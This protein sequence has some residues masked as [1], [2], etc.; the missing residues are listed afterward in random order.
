MSSGVLFQSESSCSSSEEESDSGTDVSW[1][2]VDDATVRQLRSFLDSNYSK[3]EGYKAI[4]STTSD[5]SCSKETKI[6]QR[7]DSDFVALYCVCACRLAEYDRALEAACVAIELDADNAKAYALRIYIRVAYLKQP[8]LSELRSDMEA[9]DKLRNRDRGSFAITR[10]IVLDPDWHKFMKAL[11]KGFPKSYR[12][13][14]DDQ[15]A[16]FLAQHSG[17]L[18]GPWQP[19]AKRS[20]YRVSVERKCRIL[21]MTGRRAAMHQLTGLFWRNEKII[22]G[23]GE[24]WVGECP[25]DI[26]MSPSGHRLFVTGRDACVHMFDSTQ[27]EGQGRK[28]N[29]P[30]KRVFHQS[31]V[32]WTITDI[33]HHPSRAAL[34]TSSIS[35]VLNF[36]ADY[37]RDGMRSKSLILDDTR[38]GVWATR[39]TGDWQVAAGSM[40]GGIHLFDILRE[41]TFCTAHSHNSL[42]VNA[43]CT[44]H[45]DCGQRAV[46]FSGGDD[47]T[48]CLWDTRGMRRPSGVLVGHTDGI[49]SLHMSDAHSY[50]LCSNAKDQKV[51]LWDLRTGIWGTSASSRDPILFEEASGVGPRRDAFDV[52]S[53]WHPVSSSALPGRL[54]GPALG[55]FIRSLFTFVGHKVHRTLIRARLS[56]LRTTGGRYILSGSA[57]GVMQLWDIYNPSPFGKTFRATGQPLR[58]LDS[59]DDDSD[60]A[61]DW[62]DRSH[63]TRAVT[64]HPT[65]PAAMYASWDLHVRMLTAA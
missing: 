17:R 22:R 16:R 49:C 6:G 40:V 9:L 15:P 21:S 31:H 44:P 18:P 12:M 53:R 56:P 25:Y 33:D 60:D 57:D 47:G 11:N 43:L 64:W 41:M 3:Y 29:L 7:Q 19:A 63:T 48:I 34:I 38:I 58:G 32:R 46:L 2:T 20:A 4:V 26:R 5:H 13:L 52:S 10:T 28:L 62:Y 42:D 65:I 27:L 8:Y 37:E 61:Q 54:A 24:A 59:E 23:T 39:F 14:P 45:V 1:S 50:L 51:K 55:L 30:E 35:P 36:T